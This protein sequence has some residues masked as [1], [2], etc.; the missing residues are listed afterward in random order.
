[1]INNDYLASLQ[2]KDRLHQALSP[3]Q[4]IDECALLDYPNYSNIGDRMIWVGAVMYLQQVHHAK[5]SYIAAHNSFD[6]EKLERTLKPNAPILL[7]GGGNFGDI[8]TTFQDFRELI[9]QRYKDRPIIILPQTIHYKDNKNIE[10]TAKIFNAHPNLTVCTRDEIS[11]K[12]ACQAFD[13]CR[14]LLAPDMFHQVAG[15]PNLWRGTSPTRKL[16]YLRRVDRESRKL[17]DTT[18]GLDQ[19][20]VEDWVAFQ[21]MG[22]L[23]KNV[24]YIPGLVKLVREGWQ[25]GIATPKEW[26][27]RQQWKYFH[28]EGRRLLDLPQSGRHLQAW[29]IFHSGLWQFQ[30]YR[31]VITDRMHAHLLCVHLGIPHVLLPGS[32]HKIQSCYHDWTHHV[33]YCRFVT[34]VDR[35]RDAVEELLEAYPHTP[36]FSAMSDSN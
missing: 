35:V 15:T 5:I 20:T 6:P 1:M 9:I 4:N 21:W 19:V 17:G 32:Y 8:W 10:K 22:K 25:R 24:P 18:F 27:S 12:L 2:L 33:P 30:Q 28:P 36:V 29:G 13:N 3:I 11:Y 34:D 23:P 16:L 31:L 26:F 7:N 14:V